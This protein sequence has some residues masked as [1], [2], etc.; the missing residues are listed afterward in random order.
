MKEHA[1]HWLSIL[2][3]CLLVALGVQMINAAGLLVG[4]TAGLG[5]IAQQM[6][7]NLSFGQLFFVINLPF[8]AVAIRYMGTTFT[9]RTFGAV[10]LLSLL[11]D[12]IE[13]TISLQLAHPLIASIL[14]GLLIGFGLT[15]LIRHNASIGGI[16]IMAVFLER[17]MN[18]N[19][20]KTTLCTDVS[21]LLLGLAFFDLMTVGYSLVA[22]VAVSSVLG[23]YRQPKVVLPAVVLNP[24][25]VAAKG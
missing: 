11:S 17:R 4:G 9:L 8:Y 2:E 22:F 13:N 24:N 19:A 3:A 7:P 25:V 14:G 6:L 12:L 1:T 16:T 20:A 21:I 10:T 18:I 23:R 15:I 5:L